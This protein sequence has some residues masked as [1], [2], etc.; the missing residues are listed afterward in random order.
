MFSFLVMTIV[1]GSLISVFSVLI[2]KSVFLVRTSV[3]EFKNIYAIEGSIEDTL[4]R[5]K[6]N[7]LPDTPNGEVLTVGDSTVVATLTSESNTKNYSFLADF[8]QKYF[9]SET[10]VVS[11]PGP[12]TKIK[13]WQDTQ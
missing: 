12:S 9:A 6:D 10:F 7:G 2:W 11:D 1:L 13:R 4:K 3:I 5:V 8:D